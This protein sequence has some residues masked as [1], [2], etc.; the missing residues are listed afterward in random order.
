MITFLFPGQGSQRKG[1]GGTLFDDFRELIA[2]ADEI[3]GYSIKDLCINDP[4]GKLAYTQYTQPALYIVN[5]LAYQE[6]NKDSRVEPDFVAGHSLGEYNALYAAGAFDFEQGLRLVVKRGQL[7]SQAESGAMAAVIGLK[8]KDIDTILKENNLESLSIANYNTLSQTVIAGPKTDIDKAKPVFE[9]ASAQLFI[10]LPVSG[11]F[12]THYMEKAKNQ[13]KEF[14]ADYE[15]SEPKIPVIANINAKPYE[16]GKIKMNLVQQIVSPVRWVDSVR[17]LMQKG[18]MEFEEIGPGKVLTKMVQKIKKEAEVSTTIEK[19]ENRKLRGSPEGGL[20]NEIE[21]ARSLGCEEFKKDYNL[22]YAYATGAMYHGIASKELVVRIGKAGMIGFFGTGA[23]SIGK[24]EDAIQYIQKELNNGQA[25]GM[26]LLYS[27]TEDQKVDLFLKRGVKNIEAAAF[28]NITPALVRYRLKGLMGDGNGAVVAGN[29]IFAKVSR[30]EV[31]EAFLRPAPEKIIA[32]LLEEKKITREEADLSRN[33]PMADNLIVEADSGGHTDQGVAYA[34]MPAMIKLRDQ[35]M[36][37]YQ[38]SKKIRVGAAGGIGTPEAAAA[39]FILGADFILTGSINQCTV[40]AGTSESVKDLLQEINVQ[41]TDYAPAGDMFELG[42]KVQVLKKG[43]FFPAR[44]NKLYTLYQQHNS[45]DEI[46]EKTKNQIQEKYFKRNFDEI[47]NDCREFYPPYEIDKAD[48][49]SKYKM[50]LIFRWYFHY[51][52]QQA[53]SGNQAR[54]VDYQVHTGPA[55]G[56]FNQ[57]VKGT[58]LE[59]WRKRHVD[60]IAERLMKE[61]AILLK[62]R[63]KTIFLTGER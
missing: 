6:K 34:L 60:I 39:A 42:A 13:F 3:L 10:P 52:T 53:L 14:I 5:A 9:K 62:Q 47:Y 8:A 12:H 32:M 2:I 28:M 11:A 24:I 50:A 40:E 35:M 36:K 45:I 63:L 31:A 22:K 30:P 54:K 55:L 4:E 48:K 49:N 20:E 29:K 51:S 58:E 26:N 1:M 16:Q 44:A 61:T 37:K 59:D 27:A 38:Y 23:L 57:W 17:Y 7:M 19:T 21:I 46:D 33:I 43:V 15:F 25:Y 18:E 56:A 41:D